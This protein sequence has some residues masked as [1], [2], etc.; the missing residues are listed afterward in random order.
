MRS[1]R[2]WFRFVCLFLQGL[3]P[4]NTCSSKEARMECSVAL[5]LETE[6]NPQS[7]TNQDM[8]TTPYLLTSW[9]SH[10]QNEL[11]WGSVQADEFFA[12]PGTFSTILASAQKLL[13]LVFPHEGMLQLWSSIDTYSWERWVS[14][15]AVSD[16]LRISFIVMITSYVIW[17]AC[18]VIVNSHCPPPTPYN[19]VS[20]THN[21]R[22]LGS[23]WVFSL[24]YS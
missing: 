5:P 7:P 4:S 19:S 23:C 3:P 13:M 17:F 15:H 12:A 18:E 8:D 22:E 9:F 16:I 10:L 21:L 20:Y 2:S 11:S 1:E 6:C 24:T 14:T